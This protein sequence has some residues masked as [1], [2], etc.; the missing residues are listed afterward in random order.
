MFLRNPSELVTLVNII[1]F[2]KS[3]N[4]IIK[5]KGVILGEV[6]KIKDNFCLKIF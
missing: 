6:N 2:F 4:F 5:R 3:W 1:F